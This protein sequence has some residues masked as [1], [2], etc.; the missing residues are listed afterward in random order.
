MITMKK[1]NWNDF[2]KVKLTDLGREIYF[3]QYDELI[4][5]G[6]KTIP[7]YPKEDEEGYCD[8]QLWHFMQ[9]YGPHIGMAFPN[10]VE[11][12]CFYINEGSL[13][14]VLKGDS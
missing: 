12:V 10:V 8:F 2:I 4:K 9:L 3:H 11:D 6:F 1:L 14:D 5:R 7:E 13:T